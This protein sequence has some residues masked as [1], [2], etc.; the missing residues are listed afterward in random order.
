MTN[1]FLSF[2]PNCKFRYLDLSGS[3]KPPVSSDALKPELNKEG[4]D[5]FFTPNGFKGATAVKENCINLTAFYIDV[6][7]K[8]TET[9]IDKIKS[10]LDPTFIIQTMNGFHFYWLLDRPIFKEGFKHWEATVSRWEKIEQ[11]IVTA[12]PEADKAVKDIPRIL[13]V[14]NTIY[15][16]KTDGTFK[17]KGFYKRINNTYSM[18][19]MEMAFPTATLPLGKIDVSSLATTERIKKV[20]DIEK[21]NFFERVNE[22]FPIEERDSFQKLISGSP[23][24]L[25]PTLGRNNSLHITA[26]L[27]RQAKW[28]QAKA[29][30]QIDKVG[31][32]GLET[33]P[34][35]A[36]E[37]YNTIKSA[38]EGHYA[39]S[40]KNELI[41]FNMTPAESQK[42]QLAYT[43]V[44]KDRK[45]QDKV[46]FST[47]EQEILTKNPY[48]KKN[49]VGIFF[50][51]VDG[52]YKMISD[53]DISDM[54]LA[55][56]YDDMLWGYRTKKNVSDKVACLLSIIPLLVLTDDK[57]YVANVKNGLLNIY[58]KEL[59]P[60]TPDFI[61]LIQYPVNYDPEAKSPIWDKCVAEWMSGPE[62]EEKIKLIKQFCGYCL[63]S[64]MLYD[65]ALF[66]VG[67][68]GNGKSTFIDTIAMVFGP[69]ATSH[70]DLETLYDK[71]GFDGLIG[72]RLNIVEEVHGN[73]YQSNKL[74][75]LISGEQVTIDKKYK[76]HFTFRPQTKFAFSVNMLP[77]VDDTSTATERRI[78]AVQFLNNYRDNPNY[79]LRSSVGLLAQELP[80]ILNWMIEGAIDLANDKK[81]ITTQEQ[82]KMLDEYREENSSVEGF[83]SQCI[84]LNEFTSIEVPTLYEEYKIWSMSDGGRKIK[85]NITFTK[86]VKAYGAKEKRFTYEPR[87]SGH[88]ESRFIGIE[89]APQWKVQRNRQ[90]YNY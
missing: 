32:H 87:T 46:R 24:S 71:Y 67:D 23:D 83:L 14:P 12:I 73:Y 59:K 3:N 77:R 5:S 72:K 52:V 63:S 39:Y 26:C 58:T 8:L 42:I 55:G 47:Y 54:I 57:G 66:M 86:E 81:F 28:T 75:K 60:H 11:A 4:Y 84:V 76:D 6:D 33:E 15:F 65:R 90:A 56:L 41:S 29:L 44:M 61:S 79:E 31:W 80:G 10:K 30:A 16:K 38:F 27:M 88:I 34:G 18:D 89:L 17:I 35:G 53:Q 69:D 74:K 2:F 19:E 43:K 21:N 78:I 22:E 64:S 36:Q 25:I 20:A 85:A 37:I 68:G 62:Q 48:L 82:I 49:G 51:Y 50:Q 7:K 1:N 13:R 9:E 70:L 40:Y 45:E